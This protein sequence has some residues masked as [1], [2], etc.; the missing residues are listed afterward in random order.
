SASNRSTSR[1]VPDEVSPR[2]WR[3]LSMDGPSRKWLSADKAAAEL[4]EWPAGAAMASERRSPRASARAPRAFAV[5]PAG[6]DARGEGSFTGAGSTQVIVEGVRPGRTD[7]RNG[8]TGPPEAGQG[9][10]AGIRHDRRRGPGLLAI[11]G[12]NRLE[13]KAALPSA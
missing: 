12:A 11:E 8:R 9:A 1:T 2:T 4:W 7:R 10:F 5:R 3:S 6:G 13:D